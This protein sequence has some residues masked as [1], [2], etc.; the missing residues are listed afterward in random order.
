MI[1]V[2]SSDGKE[3]EVADTHGLGIGATED[4]IRDAYG[5]V[6]KSLGFYDRGESD[7]S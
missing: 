7:S 3:S 1:K 6:K 2:Y 4:A 5:Q